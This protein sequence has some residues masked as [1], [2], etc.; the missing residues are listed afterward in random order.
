M[1]YLSSTYFIRLV[2]YLVIMTT[3]SQIR[4]AGAPVRWSAEKPAEPSDRG[5]MTIQRSESAQRLESAQRSESAQRLE[6]AAGVPSSDV[7][8]LEAAGIIFVY[9]SVLG[10]GVRLRDPNGPRI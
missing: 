4:A 3:A 7:R 9:A 2:G 1:L 10:P 5:W 6:S 8:T